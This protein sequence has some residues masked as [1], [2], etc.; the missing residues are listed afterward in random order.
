MQ[1]KTPNDQCERLRDFDMVAVR[2]DLRQECAQFVQ[3]HREAIASAKPEIPAAL[4]DR[5]ADIWE[6]LLAIADCAG[7]DWPA[8]ARGAALALSGDTLD[9][10]HPTLDTRSSLLLDIFILFAASGRDRIP[11]RALIEALNTQF[12]DRPW[13]ETRKGQ[14]STEMW[15]SEQLRPFGI[16]PRTFRNQ[17]SIL[18]GYDRDDFIDAFR[19]YLP[20]GEMDTFRTLAEK[21]VAQ[22]TQAEPPASGTHRDHE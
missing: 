18:R 6:P 20:K 5:A 3:D 16:N 4:N 10:R 19:R 8:L 7:G 22:T 9:P 1:R 13:M 11:T 2:K 17:D 21:N 14:R 15:L 12:T